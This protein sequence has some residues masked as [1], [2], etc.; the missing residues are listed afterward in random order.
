VQFALRRLSSLGN[1][2]PLAG[3]RRVPRGIKR[4]F[5]ATVHWVN[6]NPDRRQAQM[7]SDN[8]VSGL[9]SRNLN[10]GRE[11]PLFVLRA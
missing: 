3:G 1:K 4:R 7:R 6:L 10:R 2:E 5:A 9:M 8:G 11:R